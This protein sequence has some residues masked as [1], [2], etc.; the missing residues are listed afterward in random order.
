MLNADDAQLAA[1]EKELPGLALLLDEDAFASVL[2]EHLPAA[3][4]KGAKEF[5]ARYKPGRSCVVAYRVQVG[6]EQLDVYARALRREPCNRL[7]QRRAG[8]LHQLR[9]WDALLLDRP[10][11]DRA[12]LLGVEERPHQPRTATAAA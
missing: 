1:R 7:G 5:Y 11:V 4:V 6:G 10:P 9:L 12:R 2:R 3:G 8:G